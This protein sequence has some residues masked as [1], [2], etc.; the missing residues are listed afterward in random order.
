MYHNIFILKQFPYKHDFME[1]VMEE[2]IKG[3]MNVKKNISLDLLF[4]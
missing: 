3:T 4:V 1:T 2:N